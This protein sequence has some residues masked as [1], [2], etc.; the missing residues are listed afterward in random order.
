MNFIVNSRDLRFAVLNYMIFAILFG[1]INFV[2][3][4]TVNSYKLYEILLNLITLLFH[5]NTVAKLF[6][7]QIFLKP[8]ST[9]R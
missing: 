8:R 3:L 1:T 6:R 4:N 7:E 2:I 5:C 9:Y